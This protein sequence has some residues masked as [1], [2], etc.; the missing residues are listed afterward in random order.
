M[1]TKE[2]KV[3][4]YPFVDHVDQ[5]LRPTHVFDLN[6]IFGDSC[7][8]LLSNIKNYGYSKI[9]GYQYN[10]KPYLKKY[11]YKQFDSWHECFAPNKTLLRKSTFGKIDKIIEII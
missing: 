9:M 6:S 5:N 3:I 7:H 10:L 8:S 1:K 11:V 4:G 2:A